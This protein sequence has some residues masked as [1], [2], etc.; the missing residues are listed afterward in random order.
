[1]VQQIPIVFYSTALNHNPR[2]VVKSLAFVL[3]VFQVLNIASE[4]QWDTH[5]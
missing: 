4:D 1:M 2:V 5:W 3:I